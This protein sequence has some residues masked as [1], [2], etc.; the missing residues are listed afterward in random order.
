MTSVATGLEIIGHFDQ[1]SFKL[2]KAIRKLLQAPQIL[3]EGI[4][5][6]RLGLYSTS[7]T[8]HK[9]GPLPISQHLLHKLFSEA[10]RVDSLGTSFMLSELDEDFSVLWGSGF[11]HEMVAINGTEP[12]N[13]PLRKRPLVLD[14]SQKGIHRIQALP[15]FCDQPLVKLVPLLPS[16]NSN[17]NGNRHQATQRLNPA[18]CISREPPVLHPIGNGAHQQPHHCSRGYQ[19]AQKNDCLLNQPFLLT[20]HPM[21]LQLPGNAISLPVAACLVHG[22]TA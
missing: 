13:G 3:N 21:Q 5:V 11:Q 4:P 15:S 2:S 8:G 10:E 19:Q 6:R 9:G 18:G 12:T 16:R 20:T 1:V 22:G 7:N 17:R 14:E